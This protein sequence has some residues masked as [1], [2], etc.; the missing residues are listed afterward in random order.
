VEGQVDLSRR[1]VCALVR[2]GSFHLRQISTEEHCAVLL[3][4]D[5]VITVRPRRLIVLEKERLRFET[6]ELPRRVEAIKM[7]RFANI[8]IGG[9][10]YTFEP[11][12]VL[13]LEELY[14]RGLRDD[15]SYYGPEVC[16]AIGSSSLRLR[17]IFRRGPDCSDLIEHRGKGRWRFIPARVR[18]LYGRGTPTG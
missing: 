4:E 6:E 9:K 12:P 5:Q 11:M 2:D 7:P 13:A 8:V 18:E 1:D 14:R 17:D 10:H 16:K 15:S 3:D